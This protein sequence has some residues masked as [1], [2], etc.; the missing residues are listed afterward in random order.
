MTDTSHAALPD[1]DP[2]SQLTDLVNPVE[3]LAHAVMASGDGRT[4]AVSAT[5]PEGHAQNIAAVSAALTSVSGAAAQRFDGGRV[6][7]VLVTMEEGQLV[8]IPTVGG[9]VAVQ[10]QLVCEM[11][12]LISEASRIRSHLDQYLSGHRPI[13]DSANQEGAPCG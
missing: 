13:P 3:E 4:L 1:T 12:W 11:H 8:V 5:T 7:T 10:T 9:S 2:D 6:H